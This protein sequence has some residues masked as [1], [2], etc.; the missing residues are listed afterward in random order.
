ML[1]SRFFSFYR[2]FLSFCSSQIQ[3][4]WGSWRKNGE[5][6]VEDGKD[7]LTQNNFSIPYF[8][9]S[10]TYNFILAQIELRTAQF[11]TN[12][13]VLKKNLIGLLF[14]RSP[15]SF[16]RSGLRR[17]CRCT[18]TSRK[19]TNKVASHVSVLQWCSMF[20]ILKKPFE[21]LDGFKEEKLV[22]IDSFVLDPN[23]FQL[24]I[25]YFLWMSLRSVRHLIDSILL[26]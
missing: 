20:D 1:Q 5:P 21:R 16:V 11:F 18:G 3:S 25:I 24:R 14:S 17:D 8:W 4:F 23:R 10:Q 19:S 9:Q 2:Y 13:T 6:W 12:F 26:G 7:L 22:G 15:V